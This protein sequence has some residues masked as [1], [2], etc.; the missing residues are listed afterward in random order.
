MQDQSDLEDS[1]TTALRETTE[2]LGIEDTR[3]QVLGHLHQVTSLTG[4]IGI[5]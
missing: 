1:T 5:L 2:E 4:I 3:I